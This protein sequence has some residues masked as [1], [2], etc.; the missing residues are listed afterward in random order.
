MDG[1]T[2]HIFLAL[3]NPRVDKLPHGGCGGDWVN[4]R[5][6]AKSVGNGGGRPVPVARNSLPEMS[7]HQSEVTRAICL[8]F[9]ERTVQTARTCRGLRKPCNKKEN[10]WKMKSKIKRRAGK[11]GC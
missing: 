5:G 3:S 1:V 7:K 4:E 9:C 8:K 2:P 6:L 10:G 11:S